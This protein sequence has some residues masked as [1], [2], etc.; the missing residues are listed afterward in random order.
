MKVYLSIVL[1]YLIMSNGLHAAES[2][3]RDYEFICNAFKGSKQPSGLS[4]LTRQEKL[5]RINEIIWDNIKT[6]EAKDILSVVAQASPDE[7]YKLFKQA[8]EIATGKKWDC[9]AI[10]DY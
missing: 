10:R 5:N 7:K 9:P 3:E 4:S 2:S 6:Q 8:V 1:L